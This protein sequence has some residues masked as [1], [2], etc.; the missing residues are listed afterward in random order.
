VL[1]GT[2]APRSNPVFEMQA[3]RAQLPVEDYPDVYGGNLAAL[4]AEAGS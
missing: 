2:S 3:L 4:I 1:F